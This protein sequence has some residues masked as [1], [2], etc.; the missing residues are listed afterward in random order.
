MYQLLLT[1]L[2]PELFEVGVTCFHALLLPASQSLSPISLKLQKLLDMQLYKVKFDWTQ[3]D[4]LYKG[5]CVRQP[6]CLK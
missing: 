4:T 6:V 2:R 1:N 3:L 5:V